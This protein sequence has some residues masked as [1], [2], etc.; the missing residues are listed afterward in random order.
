[1]RIIY[2][3]FYASTVVLQEAL[4]GLENGDREVFNDGIAQ[5]IKNQR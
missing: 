3:Y 2:I 5:Y 4:F 1:M